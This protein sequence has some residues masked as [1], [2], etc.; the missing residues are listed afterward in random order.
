MFAFFS[1]I[2]LILDIFSMLVIARVIFSWL[3]TM[4]IVNPRN[5]FFATIGLFLYKITDPIL[6]PIKRILPNLDP[7]DIS[8]VVVIFGIYF[9]QMLIARF[10]MSAF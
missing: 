8:P 6:A 1:T 3:F 9:I 7:I 5:Q 4:N 10:F 2:N